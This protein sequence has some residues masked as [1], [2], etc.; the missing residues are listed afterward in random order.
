MVVR[1]PSNIS[2]TMS[3]QDLRIPNSDSDTNSDSDL[4]NQRP[5]KRRKLALEWNEVKTF[6]NMEEAKAELKNEKTWHTRRN[7]DAEDGHKTFYDCKYSKYCQAKRYLL[8]RASTVQVQLFETT[9][10]HTHESKIERGVTKSTREKVRQL[11]SSGI[12]KPKLILAK[13]REANLVEPTNKQL[14]NYLARVRAELEGEP[15]AWLS[16]T[17]DWMLRQESNVSPDFCIS[18]SF[19]GRRRLSICV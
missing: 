12:R 8:L 4:E 10:A 18:L 15:M 11:Y 2:R 5:I 13:I 7:Y 9:S 16:S 17:I 14:S 3:S 1:E 19:R 6:Q